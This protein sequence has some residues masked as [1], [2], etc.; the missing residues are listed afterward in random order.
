MLH[1]PKFLQNLGIFISSPSPGHQSTRSRKKNNKG[2]EAGA[3]HYSYMAGSSHY[4]YC[5]ATAPY[6]FFYFSGFRFA[7]IFMS[8]G[9]NMLFFWCFWGFICENLHFESSVFVACFFYTG[10]CPIGF[11]LRSLCFFL[12]FENYAQNRFRIA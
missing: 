10:W 1:V 3:K 8:Y 7:T 5:W 2:F 12:G 11:F 4:K 6:P 9:C